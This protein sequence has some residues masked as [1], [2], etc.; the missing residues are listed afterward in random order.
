MEKVRAKFFAD[1]DRDYVELSAVGDSCTHIRKVQPNDLA[2]FPAE[3]AAYKANTE[4][5]VG[6]TPLTD[7]PGITRDLAI[8]YKLKAVRNAEEL[9][10]LDDIATRALGMQGLAFR[11][12]AKNMLDARELA[13][14][15]AV[16]AERKQRKQ[17][18]IAGTST[19]DAA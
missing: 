7:V 12:A 16:K 2:R 17:V 18:Q 11:A 19:E 15:K 8:A 3:W 9:A 6:G 14:M 10:A 13:E 5:D 4:V 1:G